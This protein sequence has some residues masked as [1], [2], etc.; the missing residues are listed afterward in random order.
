MKKAY[1]KKK[2]AF[3]LIE[4]SIVLIIIGL[5]I[6]GVTGGASLIKSS[7]LRSAMGEARGYAVATSSFYS[8][9]NAYPGDFDKATNN[10]D[11]VGDIDGKIEHSATAAEGHEAWF[12]LKAIGAIENSLTRVALNAAL[13]VKA[14]M[15]ESKT[16][17]AGWA[18]DSYTTSNPS[19]VVVLSGPVTT[20]TSSNTVVRGAVVSGGVLTPT[21][22]LSIDAKLDDGL[23]NSGE[24]RGVGADCNTAASYDVDDDALQCGVAFSVDI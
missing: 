15:P 5:L 14:N 11:V 24:V 22:A 16:S 7:E 12:D 21:D 17:G 1:P 19:N 9:F 18:F 3:S 6:A 2:S 8:Q 20:S 10:G 23:A 13:A 4:L